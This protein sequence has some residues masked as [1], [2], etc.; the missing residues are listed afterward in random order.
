MK[1][2]SMQRT[3][4]QEQRPPRGAS[5]GP[6][7]QDTL[8]NSERIGRLADPGS[9]F[10]SATQG[11]GQPIPYLDEL[12]ALLGAD[13]FT[14]SAFMGCAAVP[15]A[16]ANALTDGESVA[17][18]EQS[19]DRKTVRHELE[20]VLQHR[21]AGTAGRGARPGA[22]T[23]RPGDASERAAASGHSGTTGGAALHGD[24][25]DDAAGWLGDTADYVGDAADY[26]GDRVGDALDMRTDEER[27]DAEEELA[28]FMSQ[29]YGV[30]NYTTSYNIGNFDGSY[31]PTSGA[32]T[33]SLAV[34]F[35]F[36]DGSAADAGWLADRSGPGADAS[37]FAWTDEEKLAYAANFISQCAAAWSRQHTFHCTRPYWDAL[38]AVNVSVAIAEAADAASAH[39]H[40]EVV[41]WPENRSGG[42]HIDRTGANHG[43]DHANHQGT[44]RAHNGG[45]LHESAEGGAGELDVSRFTRTT[46]TRSAYGAAD[47]DNP[48]P[49]TFQQG[50]AEVDA[51]QRGA[52]STFAQTMARPEIPDFALTVTGH[53]SSEGTEENNQKLSEDRARSVS[54]LLV[55]GGVKSQPTARGVGETGATE[56]P[57]WRRVD[58][59]VGNFQASQRTAVHEFG[60]MIGLGDEYPSADGTDAAGNTVSHVGEEAEHSDLAEQY[61]LVD[62]PIVRTHTDNIMSNGEVIAPQHYATFLDCLVQ[63]TGV[64]EWSTS[65]GPGPALGPGDFTPPSG[66]TS[67]A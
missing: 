44:D 55:T 31:S 10:A 15:G 46:G 22:R 58:I 19:P 30:D 8:G 61:G 1:K 17:F 9:A 5:G 54:N 33:V 50:S 18:A 36:R 34:F 43:P 6:A 35:D 64:S 49:I 21:R 29:T 66:G 13:F 16:G 28:D 47:T 38:P 26:V 65:P 59:A 63:M 3:P 60:H 24:W 40:L 53:S 57:I 39:Y 20:H 12:E 62:A 52:L 67:V 27:L 51:T 48:T 4:A 56:D 25:L 14:V 42:D 7:G 2:R 37:E 32:M 41:K 45:L 11:A 23:S